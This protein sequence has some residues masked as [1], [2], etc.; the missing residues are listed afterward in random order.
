MEE[1]NR[2]PEASLERYATPSPKQPRHA[3]EQLIADGRLVA[4][5]Q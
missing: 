4:A 5:L 2:S 3:A 1:S